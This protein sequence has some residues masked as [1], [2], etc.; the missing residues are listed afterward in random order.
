MEQQPLSFGQLPGPAADP[1]RAAWE[2]IDLLTEAM[3]CGGMADHELTA[4]EIDAA[5][6]LRGHRHSSAA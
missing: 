3:I 6:G 5:L 1:D 2:E 4:S